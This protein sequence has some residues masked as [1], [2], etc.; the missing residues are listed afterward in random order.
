MSTLNQNPK[1][2]EY[3]SALIDKNTYEQL[4][5][6]ANTFIQPKIKFEAIKTKAREIAAATNEKNKNKSPG[7][8]LEKPTSTIPEVQAMFNMTDEEYEKFEKTV[9]EHEN[10]NFSWLTHCCNIGL[11]P[12]SSESDSTSDYLLRMLY[13]KEY[14]LFLKL[15]NVVL[16]C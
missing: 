11:L 8:E 14:E 4:T 9:S 15:T 6:L 10:K 3:I 7:E 16:E 2:P 13:I 1:L 5:K 12:K